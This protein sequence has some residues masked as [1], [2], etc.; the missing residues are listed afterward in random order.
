MQEMT[1]RYI[2]ERQAQRA[3]GRAIEEI[4][5]DDAFDAINEYG[6]WCFFGDDHSRGHG[7]P[8]NDMDYKCQAL[9]RGYDCA[10]KDVIDA[11]GNNTCVPWEIFYISGIGGGAAA[12][13]PTCEAF[14]SDPCAIAACSIEG[15]F[16]LHVFNAALGGDGIDQSF[17][18]AN[19]FD[20]RSGCPL[21]G[22]CEGPDCLERECCGAFPDRYPFRPLGGV[23]GCCGQHTFD[24]TV[25]TCCG[26]D[27]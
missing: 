20:D 21:V 11:T 12:L 17:S 2:R 14:N 19:G 26:D 9:H 24:A 8:V 4:F 16:V 7:P 23:R 18:H 15:A 22:E 3:G 27:V 10:I 6:C 5:T 25:L 13:V 1:V